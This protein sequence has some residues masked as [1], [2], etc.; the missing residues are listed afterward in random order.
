VLSVSI[1]LPCYHRGYLLEKTLS[2]FENYPNLEVIVVED[3]M[4]GKTKFLA[5]KYNARHIQHHRTM[6]Y[7]PFQSVAKIF[8]LGI[9]AA[10]NDVII[11][12][13]PEVF[14]GTSVISQLVAPLEK[15]SKIRTIAKTTA[16]NESRKIL[17]SSGA[18]PQAILKSTLE[19]I[20]CYEEQFFGYG[21]ED[22]FLVWL[23]NRNGIKDVNTQAQT[24]HQWHSPTPFDPFTGHANRAICWT[25][26]AE[27]LWENRPFKANRGPLTPS[28]RIAE[29]DIH[30]L[31]PRA[32]EMFQ[33]ASY[34]NWAH[35]WQNG[36]RNDDDTLAARDTA[37][38]AMATHENR[39]GSF[40][41][42]RIAEAAWALQWADKCWTEREKVLS[43]QGNKLWAERLFTCHNAHQSL[44]SIAVRIARRVLNGEEPRV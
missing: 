8:N 18:R 30:A 31:L 21:Y 42:T 34:A 35:H 6:E 13:A 12:Q 23:L 43:N 16:L 28:D 14:H 2:S 5:K 17:G 25:L 26:A 11:L 39:K 41:A 19:E 7:P 1:V 3:D 22:D 40:V 38:A 27:M 29:I 10:K 44:A 24:F 15:N 4:D 37:S 32:S 36:T 9:R 20:G 33:N